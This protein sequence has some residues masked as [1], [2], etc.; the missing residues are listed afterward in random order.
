MATAIVELE[1]YAC[2][3]SALRAQGDLNARKLQLL[4]DLQS[5]F[6]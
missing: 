1:A 5:I 4:V 3:V 6:K 2:V